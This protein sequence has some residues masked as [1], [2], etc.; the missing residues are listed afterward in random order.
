MKQVGCIEHGEA[1]LE[2]AQGILEPAEALQAEQ[3]RQDCAHC[4]SWWGQELS[5]QAVTAVDAGVSEALQDLA[6]PPR[7]RAFGGNS[8]LIA[9]T[10]VLAAG[11]LIFGSDSS[12][13]E[14]AD[15]SDPQEGSGSVASSSD[16]DLILAE[17]FEA[18][19][20]GQPAQWVVQVGVEAESEHG[21]DEVNPDAIFQSGLEAGGLG[22]WNDHS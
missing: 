16:P 9:A 17:G 14:V 18:A 10:T 13:N 12:V 6:A 22:G 7:R 8:L 21:S 4:A 19:I 5:G 11:I 2:L 15:M 3:I 20:G 1:V